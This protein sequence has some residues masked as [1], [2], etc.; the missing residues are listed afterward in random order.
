MYLPL[1]ACCGLLPVVWGVVVVYYAVDCVGTV[2]VFP[3]LVVRGQ[4][5][6]VTW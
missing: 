5:H 6:S 4:D 1:V 3:F 2:C